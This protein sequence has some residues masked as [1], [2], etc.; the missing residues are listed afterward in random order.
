M[1]NK[2]LKKTKGLQEGILAFSV[3]ILVILIYIII[4]S[5]I[6]LVKKNTF[7]S[8]AKNLYRSVKS[9]NVT[10][11]YVDSLSN[12]LDVNTNLNYFF[13]I[14]KNEVIYMLVYNNKLVLEL[15]YDGRSISE[16]LISN[17]DSISKDEYENIVVYKHKKLSEEKEMINTSIDI[18]VSSNETSK[19]EETK[20]EETKQEEIKQ[21]EKKQEEIKQE[22]KNNEKL[23][24]QI[25]KSSCKTSTKKSFTKYEENG[26]YIV[27]L[28]MGTFSHSGYDI[29]V[30]NVII[31]ENNAIILIDEIYPDSFSSN[32]SSVV[33]SPCAMVAFNKKP[34]KVEI[35]KESTYNLKTSKERLTYEMT[36]PYECS[37]K[38]GGYI[39]KVDN[40]SFIIT[41]SSGSAN[42]FNIVGSS[43]VESRNGVIIYIKEELKK[44]SKN[45][46]V[47]YKRYINISSK[48]S[49][50][51]IYDI[52]N[53]STCVE[54]KM[55]K[56]P[57]EFYVVTDGAPI[58]TLNLNSK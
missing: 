22:T 4:S 12:K 34:D 52:K 17:P 13:I 20:Q 33:T 46:K 35:V 25:N 16:E 23:T 18:E 42:N 58:E 53:N 51:E 8:D 6:K 54:I 47:G 43:V 50:S 9:S 36:E 15:D 11:S 24:Y 27:N 31:E 48:Y 56:I 26:E 3:T 10:T 40:N 5:T 45:T 14:N 49:T 29:K 7:I 44:K 39:P 30:K 57:S 19:D 2:K 38:I 32:Y 55:N 37:I 41:V 28:A 1:E 21:E